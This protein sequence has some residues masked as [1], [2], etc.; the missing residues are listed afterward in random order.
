M[1]E[2]IF[3]GCFF[4]RQQSEERQKT[5]TL[6]SLQIFKSY[7]IF[8]LFRVREKKKSS[9]FIEAVIFFLAHLP[10]RINSKHE[11]YSMFR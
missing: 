7:R 6:T 3:I 4:F 1:L 8:T 10:L 2:N 11:E 5:N 9:P